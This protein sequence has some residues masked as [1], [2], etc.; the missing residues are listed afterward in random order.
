MQS[1]DEGGTDRSGSAQ[2]YV[3]LT[4]GEVEFQRA[5]LYG[6]GWFALIGLGVVVLA[7]VGFAALSWFWNLDALSVNG[8]PTVSGEGR[9]GQ[10]FYIDSGIGP[11]PGSTEATV[12]VQSVTASTKFQAADSGT[13][14]TVPIRLV[15]CRQETDIAPIDIVLADQVRSHCTSVR[16]LT[17][18]GT[19]AVGEAADQLL[20]AL[21]LTAAGDYIDLSAT[22]GYSQGRRTAEVTAESS[23]TVHA[24]R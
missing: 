1:M 7:V 10:T 15:A 18:G 14:T 5:R 19:L 20:Y 4:P 16:A 23:T 11:A 21:P 3:P 8:V 17:P 12:Q 2:P 13:I 6:Q 22:L 9:I 24:R